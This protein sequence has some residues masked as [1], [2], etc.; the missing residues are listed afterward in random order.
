MGLA[1]SAPA[2]L[3]AVWLGKRRR[4]RW[5]ELRRILLALLALMSVPML[6]VLIGL[7]IE[8]LGVHP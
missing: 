3:L 6:L 7:L 1:L 5:R 8:L 4:E 2:G